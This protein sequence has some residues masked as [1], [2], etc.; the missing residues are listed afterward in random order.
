MIG[1]GTGDALGRPPLLA[2]FVSVGRTCFAT[3]WMWIFKMDSFPEASR[4]VVAGAPDRILWNANTRESAG[5]C[6]P[7]G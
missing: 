1:R 7:N 3:E 5:G 4:D 2:A 6:R